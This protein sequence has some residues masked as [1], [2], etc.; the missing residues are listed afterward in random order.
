MNYCYICY[1]KDIEDDFVCDMCEQHYCEDCSYCFTLH[2]QFQG[3]RCY[4][5]ADQSRINRLT[6]EMISD[7]KLKLLID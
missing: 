3:S 6:K 5:C 1:K 4:L 2:Y 7:N